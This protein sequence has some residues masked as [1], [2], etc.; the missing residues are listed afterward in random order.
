MME[1]VNS[2][3]PTG[4]GE[5]APQVSLIAT[6]PQEKYKEKAHQPD[7]GGFSRAE[8]PARD[9]ALAGTPTWMGCSGVCWRR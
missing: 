4:R 5:D 8:G 2:N 7:P 1:K 9:E 6:V 3:H